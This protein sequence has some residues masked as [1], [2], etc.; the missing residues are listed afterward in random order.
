MRRVRLSRTYQS[1]LKAML[2]QGALKFGTTFALEKQ[3]QIN[4]T[5]R[6]FL[7]LHP[8]HTSDPVLGIYADPVSRTPFVLLYDFD[9]T[10]LRI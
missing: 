10:E 1:E 8:V 9:D 2:R 4:R 5:I 3:A 6:K 7:A